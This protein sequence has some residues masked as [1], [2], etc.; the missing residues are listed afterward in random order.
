MRRFSTMD[1]ITKNFMQV[2]LVFRYDNPYI[3]S[4]K[5]AMAPENMLSNIG[6]SLSL[7]L[8]MTVMFFFEILEFVYTT[9]LDRYQVKKVYAAN[10][11]HLP[12]TTLETPA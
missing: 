6:G 9:A 4:D 10:G 1:L 3:V 2:N 12:T 7:W 5:P 11:K 8:G